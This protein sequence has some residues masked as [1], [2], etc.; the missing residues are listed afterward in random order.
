M[1]R[2]YVVHRPGSVGRR[3]PSTDEA[4]KTRAAGA[5]GKLLLL[6]FTSWMVPTALLLFAACLCPSEALG[7]DAFLKGGIVAHPS[8]LGLGDRWLVSLGSDWA[9]S[10]TLY[11]GGEVQS[12]YGSYTTG[13]KVHIRVIPLNPFFNVKF[14]SNAPIARAFGGGG[15]GMI[16][17]LEWT[18][19]SFFPSVVSDF[20]Y[21][22]RAA[23]HVMGGIELKKKLVIE[24]TVQRTFQSSSAHA[25]SAD[26][27]LALS[28]WTNVN[29]ILQAGLTW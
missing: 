24:L 10:R 16:S 15:L 4:G 20:Q 9:V 7:G 18:E 27:S 6:P 11:L 29:W 26:R 14:K 23:F 8:D 17:V 12:A 21:T 28:P 3:R 19:V 25:A 22:P 2:V 5:R 13:G 1:K